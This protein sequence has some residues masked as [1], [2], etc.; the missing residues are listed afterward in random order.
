L[1]RDKGTVMGNAT[2]NRYD[3]IPST[4]HQV[5]ISTRSAPPS[6]DEECALAVPVAQ[7]AEPV[8]ELGLDAAALRSAGFHGRR[9][10]TLVLPGRG[11]ILRVA[12]GVGAPAKVDR[13]LVREAVAEFARAVPQ[14]RCLVVELPGSDLGIS[15]ADYA[16]AVTEGVL[17]ARWR[18]TV[19][20][21][22]EPTLESLILVG[23]PR[24]S[25][26]RRRGRGAVKP[27]PRP[28][29]SAGTSRT[30]PPPP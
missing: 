18:F 12:V 23:P 5:R 15:T 19:A 28:T 1:L 6:I 8:R 17:L 2:I 20:T 7:D 26:Q 11:G 25:L 30:V 16:Q 13:T 22:P 21:D 29:T 24:T 14:H 9:G 3:P 4:R 27:S 10:E